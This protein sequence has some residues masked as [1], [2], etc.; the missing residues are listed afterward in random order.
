MQDLVAN[1][2]QEAK[3]MSLQMEHLSTFPKMRR[4][5]SGLTALNVPETIAVLVICLKDSQ[6]SVY[7]HIRGRELLQYKEY[8]ANVTKKKGTWDKV[9]EETRHKPLRVLSQLS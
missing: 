9:L 8:K 4:S 6:D 3:V 1:N 2:I 7:S 5:V